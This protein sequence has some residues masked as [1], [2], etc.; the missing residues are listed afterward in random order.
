[1]SESSGMKFL[2]YQKKKNVNKESNTQSRMTK[3][4][5]DLNNTIEY[6]DLR[7]I[8]RT[9]HPTAAE[10]T[11]FSSMHRTVSGTIITRPQNKAQ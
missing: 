4:E 6:L 2:K 5:I 9:F 7:D 1:M 8:C 10:Y 3:K 11:L